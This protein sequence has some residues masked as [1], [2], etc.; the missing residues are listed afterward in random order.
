MSASS[1]TAAFVGAALREIAAAVA[2]PFNAVF[3]VF[4]F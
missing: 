3:S 1:I 4:I 2:I